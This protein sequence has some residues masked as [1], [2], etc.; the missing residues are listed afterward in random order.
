MS[1]LD[2]YWASADAQEKESAISTFLSMF[3]WPHLLTLCFIGTPAR[4]LFSLFLK[5]VYTS[6]CDYIWLYCIFRMT[7]VCWS[8]SQEA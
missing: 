8:E 3:I 4:K 1:V 7:T 6:A 5:L 2:L